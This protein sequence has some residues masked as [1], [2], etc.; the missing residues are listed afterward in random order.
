MTNE[1]IAEVQALEMA[2][3]IWNAEPREQLPT[4]EDAEF[5][6]LVCICARALRGMDSPTETKKYMDILG[7]YLSAKKQK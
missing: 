7:S 4:A 5:V 3:E 1:T 6:M 2:K